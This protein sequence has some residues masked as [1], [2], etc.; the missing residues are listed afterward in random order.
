MR[1]GLFTD[2]FRPSINGIVFVVEST[3][4]HLEA[5]GH[6]VF[7]LCPG[8]SIRPER[9]SDEPEAEP[10]DDHIIRFPSVKGFFYDDYDTSIFFPPRAVSKIRDLGLD[11]IHI[12][13]PAQLGLLGVYAA[14]KDD[15]PVV[16]EHSTDVYEYAEHYPAALPGMLALCAL[17]PFSLKVR[18]KDVRQLLSLYRPRRERL[19]WTHEII[20]KA[21][22]LIYSRCDAVI[23]LSRKSA[24]QLESWQE[25]SDYKYEVTLLPNG[26]DALPR[27]TKVELADFRKRWSISAQ[28][29]VVTFVGRLGAEKNLDLLIPAI[30][31]VLKARPKAKLLLVGDFEYRE[32]LEEAARQSSASDQIIF[33]GSMPREELGVVYEASTVF[34]FP[35]LKDTQGWVLHEAA[36]AGLPIVLIDQ[37]LSEVVRESVNGYFAKNTAES[38]A[39]KIVKILSDKAIYNKFSENS[40]K[41]AAGFSE[42]QSA[43]TLEGVYK[44]LSHSGLGA[45]PELFS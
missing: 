39:E 21:L 36:H 31:L 41:L 8:G 24:R 40:R 43:E 38:F 26:V 7:I 23:A 42:R 27:P 9:S 17:L 3:R 5:L 30:E 34:A 6:E 29:E 18:G 11:V 32:V 2:T 35:S 28:D 12:F 19:E 1:I 33:A 4:R 14:F 22:T 20:E 25:N 15:I 10:E 45:R 44:D 37:D 13:T 16:A